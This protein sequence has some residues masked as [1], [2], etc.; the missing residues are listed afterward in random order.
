M[1]DLPPDYRKPN[2]VWAEVEMPDVADW[3]TEANSRAARYKNSNPETGAVKGEINPSTA[4]I[5]DEIPVGGYYRFKT[6]PNM[7]GNWMIGGSMK[8][9]RVL[10]PEEVQ[11]INEAAGVADLPPFS[12]LDLLEYYNK[13]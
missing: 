3:Q 8:V 1:K 13:K 12:P 5:T 4:A 11:A 10:S 6:N 9:N 7:T 2:Q